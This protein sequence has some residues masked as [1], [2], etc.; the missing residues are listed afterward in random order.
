MLWRSRAA[1]VLLLV[2]FAP[3]GIFHVFFQESFTTRYALPLVPLM[4][5]LAVRGAWALGRVPAIAMLSA[6]VLVSLWTVI[7]VA[8]EYTALGSP[9]SRALADVRAEATRVGRVTLGRHVVYNRA[10]QAGLDTAGITVLT[11]P[12]A[13]AWAEQAQH[14][15]DDDRTPLWLL[16][17]PRRTHLAL[18]D[19]AA[20]IVRGE[21]R[22]PFPSAT[23]LGGERP[24][25]VDW[26]EVRRPGWLVVEGWHLT[27][28]TAGQAVAAGK[29]LG[30]GPITA[31]V[32]ARP[33]PARMMIGG[34]HLGAAGDPDIAFTV[35]LDGREIDAW[36]ASPASQFFL[37]FTDLPAGALAGSGRW[38]HLTVEA[39]RTDNGQYA[40]QGAIE[41]FNL[42]NDAVPMV[43]FDKGWHELELNTPTGMLWRWTSERA[44]L[45]IQPVG[46]DVVLEVTGESPMRSFVRPSRVVV[47]AG[48]REF[49]RTGVAAD[50]AWSIDVPA[51][52]LAAS[53]G[54]VTIETDQ[55]F[56][57]ADRRENADRRPLGLRILSVA[58]RPAS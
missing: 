58:V 12:P 55:V 38:L 21:Y 48:G 31:Y 28:E 6:S 9:V 40:A 34:R 16:G 51:A 24:S 2:T 22:W 52:V 36:T 27:P 45:R 30:A 54:V 46:R 14:L 42:Q 26:I 37:R 19:P 15:L 39:R 50:F 10:I 35:R 43:G 32:R 18:A 8:A 5:Y 56:R 25:G 13:S 47:R 33:G 49:M 3:Y 29:G 11:A 7:P 57:P 20:R 23:F 17:I 44:D 53:G 41:Q 1:F 4:A